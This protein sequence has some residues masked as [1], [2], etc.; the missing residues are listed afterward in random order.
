MIEFEAE[1]EKVKVHGESYDVR[2]PT[3]LDQQDYENSLKGKKG[4]YECL[5]DYLD[6]LGLPKDASGKLSLRQLRTLSE[7]LAGEK[8]S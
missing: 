7:H 3:L 1:T 8:K 2:F 6:S 5:Q 4:I